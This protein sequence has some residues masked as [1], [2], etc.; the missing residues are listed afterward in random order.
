[1]YPKKALQN[2]GWLKARSDVTSSTKRSEQLKQAPASLED[3]M[4]VD[5]FVLPY[6][7]MLHAAPIPPEIPE[8]LALG[9]VFFTLSHG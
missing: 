3:A 6:S 2:A 4:D 5:S 1:M 9:Y 7:P 8:D